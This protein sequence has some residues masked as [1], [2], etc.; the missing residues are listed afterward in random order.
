MGQVTGVFNATADNFR[1]W[2]QRAGLWSGGLVAT[3]EPAAFSKLFLDATM[4]ET[5]PE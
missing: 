3:D 1:K 4:V 5:Q 2:T